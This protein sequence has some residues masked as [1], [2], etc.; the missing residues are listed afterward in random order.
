MFPQKEKK[1]FKKKQRDKNAQR[2]KRAQKKTEEE[3]EAY[4]KEI[5]LHQLLLDPR[6]LFQSADMFEGKKWGEQVGNTNN[7]TTQVG[8]GEVGA[9][10]VTVSG[11]VGT[12]TQVSGSSPVISRSTQIHFSWSL[13]AIASARF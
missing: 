5:S 10:Q 1:I 6:Q 7:Y 13:F 2:E 3:R 9:T 8:S 12:M 4:L 11:K